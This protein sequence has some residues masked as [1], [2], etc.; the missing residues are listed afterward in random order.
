VVPGS[1]IFWKKSKNDKGIIVKNFAPKIWVLTT[2]YLSFYN[3]RMYFIYRMF[4]ATGALLYVGCTNQIRPRLI[5]HGCVNPWYERVVDVK[6]ELV[7]PDRAEALKKERAVIVSENPE[8][9]KNKRA[10]EKETPLE[11]AA[12]YEQRADEIKA[13]HARGWTA[14]QL[15]EKFKISRQRIYQIVPSAKPRALNDTTPYLSDV[16]K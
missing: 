15:A 1:H 16:F 2:S 7:G 14:I 5:A 11:R 8:L 6:L 10:P 9:N 3:A 12:R 13:L 4:D